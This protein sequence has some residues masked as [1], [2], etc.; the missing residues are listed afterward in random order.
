MSRIPWS[1]LWKKEDW[2]AVWIGLIILALVATGT[3]T[4]IPKISSWT[5]DLTTAINIMDIPYFILLALFLLTLTGIP[6]FAIKRGRTKTYCTSFLIVFLLAFLAQLTS[7]QTNIKES[8][9]AYALWALFFGLLISNIIG[10]PK[11]FNATSGLFIKIG[12]VVLGAEILFNIILE[13][14]ALGLF[15]VTVGLAIVWYFCYYIARKLGLSK[16]FSAIMSTAT[17]VCGVSAAIAASGAVKGDKKEVS[18]TISLVLLF[19]APMIIAMPIIG[20]ELGI[21]DTIFGAWV[22]GCIDN[23][24]SVVASGALYSEEAMAIASIIKMSQNI[25]IGITAFLLALY[26]T[27]KVERTSEKPKPVE[28]WY[29]FPKFIVGFLLASIVFSFVLTPLIGIQPVKALLKITKG[30]RGW[31]FA[32]T[33]VCIGLQTKFTELIKIGKGKPLLVFIVAT[34]FDVIISLISAYVFF[35]GTIFP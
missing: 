33:F 14:G 32:L 9:L 1:S 35:G 20:K 7:R 27:L 13:A 11:W 29:R 2:W 15:E 4:W 30:F 3:I 18:Y 5:F 8:G 17:S 24:A 23:T 28:I 26:W 34:L 12:L 6:I 10:T 22:G 25:L 21:P 19:S 31:F 16:S